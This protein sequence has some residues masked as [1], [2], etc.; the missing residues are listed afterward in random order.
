MFAPSSAPPPL[1][2]SLEEL[3][4]AHAEEVN[5]GEDLGY[6]EEFAWSDHMSPEQVEQVEEVE[7]MEVELVMEVDSWMPPMSWLPEVEE[8]MTLPEVEELVEE[9][10]LS[11]LPAPPAASAPAPPAPSLSPLLVLDAIAISMPLVGTAG[12]STPTPAPTATALQRYHNIRNGRA[13]ARAMRIRLEFLRG[14]PGGNCSCDGRNRVGPESVRCWCS[15]TDGVRVGC[16]LGPQDAD[17]SP[18]ALPLHSDPIPCILT[19]S[20]VILTPSPHFGVLFGL[21]RCPRPHGADAGAPRRQGA[22]AVAD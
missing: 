10:D 20:C 12:G 1:S 15:L 4:L 9:V 5:V 16:V 17:H 22:G 3:P 18:G 13:T 6:G 19:P 8:L 2:P 7:Q 11:C 14:V 21:H